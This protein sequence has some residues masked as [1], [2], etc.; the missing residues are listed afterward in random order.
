MFHHVAVLLVAFQLGTQPIPQNEVADAL[1][2]AQAL[3]F[4][5]KFKDSAD[6]LLRVDEQ[7]AAKPDRLPEKLNVKL[8]LA[9]AYI[10]L[11]DGARAKAF[12]RD[13]YGLNPDYAL[14]Q[15]EFSPKVI[16]LA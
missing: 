13:L 9:L 6:L 5:A 14:D 8:Q 4:E 7:L 1:S 15:A 3:Y 12:L 11:N 16:S 10:G 2:R